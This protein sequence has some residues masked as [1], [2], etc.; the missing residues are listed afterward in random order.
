[1]SKIVI[2][3]NFL[4][5]SIGG[6]EVVVH[7]I[8]SHLA[9]EHEVFVLTRRIPG[10][11]HANSDK[12]KVVEY[13]PGDIQTFL[14]KI[15][16]IEPNLIFIYS[17]VFD[18]FRPLLTKSNYP[19]VIA[20]CGAN[21][22]YSNHTYTKILYR[23]I[24]RVARFI[25]HSKFDRDYKLCSAAGI[26]EKTSIIPN[27]V[28]TTE[29]D[30]NNLTRE[31]LA[32]IYKL[33]PGKRW[34]L[35]VANFFPGKGQNHLIP[36]VQKLG[37]DFEYIQVYNDIPFAIGKQLEQKWMFDL[38]KAK[39]PAVCVKNAPREHVVGF[40][41]R[42]NVLAFT[43]EKEVAPIVILEAMAAKLPWVAAEV[44][45]V[46]G[47]KGGRFIP[48][49]RNRQYHCLFDEG[50]YELF[51]QAILDAKNSWG[52]NGRKQI[53]D[54]LTWEKVLPQYSS[55]FEEILCRS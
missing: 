19:L 47:L 27:G 55:L 21:W 7:N 32:L 43:S 38:R 23:N 3:T 49:I 9:K 40:F 26:K 6:A 31:E 13:M 50:I 22:L 24:N 4:F 33:D 5:P 20:L 2:C 17:D 18:F 44:G 34:V 39:V 29:F 45:H 36:I 53:Q 48:A 16:S 42:S 11:K 10:R 1:M 46:R 30:T 8:A 14:G 41:N 28:D 51:V 54:E 52:D 12:F 15:K 37:K 35:N 25:C